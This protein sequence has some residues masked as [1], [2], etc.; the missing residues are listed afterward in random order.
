MATSEERLAKQRAQLA[1]AEELFNRRKAELAQAERKKNLMDAAKKRKDDTRR[2]VLIGAMY[3]ERGETYPDQKERT[4]K[5]L[6]KFLQR[7]DD[8]ALF[9]L[10]PLANEQQAAQSEKPAE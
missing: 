4:L 6:D 10:Q 3:M 8:R 7:P 9:E 2:K 5:L 1:K